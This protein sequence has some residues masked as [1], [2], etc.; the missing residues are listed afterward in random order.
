MK[1]FGQELPGMPIYNTQNWADDINHKNMLATFALGAFGFNSYQLSAA[2]FYPEPPNGALYN[3]INRNETEFLD[4]FTQ[5]NH[6]VDQMK[7]ILNGLSKA[8]IDVLKTPRQ[9]FI[10][11]GMD[12][13][14]PFG[15]E[16]HLYT[17]SGLLINY[18]NP[19]DGLGFV[20]QNDQ[21]VT[22]FTTEDAHITFSNVIFINA[23]E[24]YYG[25]DGNWVNEGSVTLS[26]NN[27]TLSTTAN[28]I[29]R[30]KISSLNTLPSNLAEIYTNGFDAIRGE[31]NICVNVGMPHVFYS[32]V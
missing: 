18:S 13:R 30:L 11:L 21:Y 10:V 24:G 5:K 7:P 14:I 17:Q 12:T 15:T 3:R 6:R 29:Y 27:L 22:V 1:N 16:Q 32:C 2:E 25:T 20:I 8:F 9:N 19:T 23:T 26:N 4:M 31:K 28:R